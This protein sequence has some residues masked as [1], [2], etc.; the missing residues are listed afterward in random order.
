MIRQ[1]SP[2]K[3][4]RQNLTVTVCFRLAYQ[5]ILSYSFGDLIKSI[6]EGID[7]FSLIRHRLVTWSE[8]GKHSVAAILKCEA[9]HENGPLLLRF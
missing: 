8:M 4:K 9:Y 1:Y 3:I 6:R 5:K 2:F 7:L